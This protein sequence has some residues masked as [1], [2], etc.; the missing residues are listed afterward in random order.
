MTRISGAVNLDF[1]DITINVDELEGLLGKDL[2]QQF[3]TCGGR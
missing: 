2:V 1:G 3:G